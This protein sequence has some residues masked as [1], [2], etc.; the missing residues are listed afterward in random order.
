LAK[1]NPSLVDFVDQSLVDF[2][3]LSLVDF[4]DPSLKVNYL[5]LLHELMVGKVNKGA[6]LAI[7][8]YL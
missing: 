3:D 4:V 6:S 8:W 1:F 7:V 5:V 2:V